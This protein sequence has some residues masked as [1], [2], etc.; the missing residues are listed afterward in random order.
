MDLP[1]RVQDVV[2]TFGIPRGTR[3]LVAVSGGPDSVALAR[4]LWETRSAHGWDLALGHVDHGI[5]PES[6]RVAARVRDIAAALDLPCYQERLALGADAS[7]TEGREARYQALSRLQQGAGAQYL[8]LGH[9]RD[10]QAE[11]VLIRVLSGS[12]PAGLSGMLLQHGHVLRP[13][14]PFRRL[15]LVQYLRDAGWDYWDDPANQDPRH[16]RSWIRTRVLP[17]LRERLPWVDDELVHVAEQAAQD[18]AA[19]DLVLELLPGL[20]PRREPT[21]VSVAAPVLAAYDSALGESVLRALARRMGWVLSGAHAKRALG[22][23]REGQSGHGIELG[24]GWELALDLGR[25]HLRK[26]VPVT[27]P[28][29][30]HPVDL[31]PRIP[32]R[33]HLGRWTLAWRPDIAA[34]P[35]DR[36]G[37]SSWF[38]GGPLSVRPWQPGDAIRPLGGRGSRAV[39]KCF[40]EARISREV[41]TQWPV[42]VDASGQVVWVPGVCRSAALLPQPGAEALRVDAHVT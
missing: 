16:L 42:V 12:G 2:T 11:T 3:V 5:H 35:P 4:L 24:H 6:S 28:A 31:D 36:A 33:A 1:A 39:V 34:A 32:G 23:V 29:W 17:F 7:E 37:M 30:L 15:E 13:L 18:R 41:R 40:Q 25:A 14:L 10:D 27:Q 20:E 26:S 38:A 9:H 8:A 21:G 19:W 22:F